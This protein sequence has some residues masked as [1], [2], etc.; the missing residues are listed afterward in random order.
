MVVGYVGGLFC[1][2]L[3]FKDESFSSVTEF[4]SPLKS[5]PHMFLAVSLHFYKDTLSL[6]SIINGKVAEVNAATDKCLMFTFQKVS[7]YLYITF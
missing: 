5:G 4:F 1:R 2:T 3:E 7:N 6:C